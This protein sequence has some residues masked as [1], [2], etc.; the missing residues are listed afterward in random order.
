MYKHEQREVVLHPHTHTHA[1]IKS[2]L[3]EAKRTAITPKTGMILLIKQKHHQQLP[4]LSS[5][6]ITQT[7]SPI[8]KAC[9][10]NTQKNSYKLKT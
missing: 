1:H 9:M 2:A 3:R 10:K 4:P 6:D 8:T 5:Q 7:L